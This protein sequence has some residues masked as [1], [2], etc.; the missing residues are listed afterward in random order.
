MAKHIE[1]LVWQH[2]CVLVPQFGGFVTQV[3]SAYLTEG[4]GVFMPPA[5][6]VGFN[7][8]LLGNDGILV[9][10]YMQVHGLQEAEAKRLLQTDILDMRE[11]LLRQG[12]YG[13]GRLGELTQDEDGEIHFT[14]HNSWAAPEFF[15][16][17][18]LD[19]PVLDEPAVAEN[20]P[21]GPAAAQDVPE[22]ITLR[23]NRKALH[24]VLSVAA[25]VLLFFMVS[26][27][28]N[29]NFWNKNQ[30]LLAQD[31]LTSALKFMP[32]METRQTPTAE[33]GHLPSATEAPAT[34]MPAETEAPAPSPADQPASATASETTPE[35]TQ[36]FA[37]VIA[38]AIP[39]QNALDYVAHL[40]KRGIEGASI[41]KHGAMVRVL[42]RGFADES[43]ARRKM[44]ALQAAPE[45]RGAWILQM[46]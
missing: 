2:E 36:E 40:Q 27:P 34:V 33:T 21:T 3:Q 26:T 30:A 8:K 43:E 14:P 12:K 6:T 18:A 37:V 22:H 29:T 41:Y 16:L 11:Q 25:A 44:Q 35:T 23:I 38:S 13:L 4:D 9:R 7:D 46:K 39:E 45:F 1:T 31:I 17:E 10:S 15:G 20:I 28:V 32:R 42:F 5:R 24:T 19:F